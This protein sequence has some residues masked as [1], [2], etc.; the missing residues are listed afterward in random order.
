MNNLLQKLRGTG[1]AVVTP[2]KKDFSVDFDSIKNLV[3]FLIENGVNYIVVQ[4]TTGEASTLNEQEKVLSRTA[5]VKANNNR[6]PLVIG[7]GSNDTRSVTEYIVNADLE[8]FCAILSVAPFYNR[9]TQNGL[10]R[11]FS[12]IS[13][14]S[15]LPII[16]YNVPLRTGCNLEPSTSIKLAKNHKNIIGIKDAS[17][18]L[19]QMSNLISNRPKD[20]LIVSGDDESA[21]QSIL[22]GADGVISVAAGCIPKQFSNII[23][24]ALKNDADSSRKHFEDIQRLLILLFKEGNPT[25]LK[26]ALSINKLCENILRLPLIPASNKLY[27]E[28]ENYFLNNI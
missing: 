27:V 2:F 10:Y 28:I 14:V 6:V 26:A 9:P 25:G 4:G 17:G 16:L 21:Y 13:S 23:N 7:I 19:N 22:K 18:D 5:Y 8:G 1:V 24:I 3:D 11:H 12:A 20:F 15:S